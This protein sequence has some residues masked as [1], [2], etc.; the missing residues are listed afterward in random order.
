MFPKYEYRNCSI[1]V[2]RRTNQ[3]SYPGRFHKHLEV[4]VVCSAQIRVTI[5]TQSYL[6]QPG[7]L[8]VVFPN[9]LHAIEAEGAEVVAM[10]VDFE[11]Y[12]AFQDVLLHHYPE[13]PVLR[14]GEFH[15][16]V[17]DILN[18]MVSLKSQDISHRTDTLEG[19]AN[20][21]LGELLSTMKLTKRSSDSSLLQKLI[22]Y[23]MQ[24]YTSDI[25]LDRI[26]QS[27]GYSKYYISREI[28]LLFGCNLCTLINSYRLSMA[29]NLLLSGDA[30]ISKIAADC[31][32]RN[33]SAFN[34]LFLKQIGMTPGKY[35]KEGSQ[36]P[37]MPVVYLKD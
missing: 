17:Y 1:N 36:A 11:K 9:V 14:K 4:M 15:P 27:L 6:L 26:A 18:R 23:I 12:P 30:P 35:R 33:Q 22:F 8:Y 32:F 34:R 21:L 29:Q 20:A 19:Y 3:G 16:I 10:I 2:S 13:I 7:D 25:T 5:D 28:R 37:E 31:G 24:N